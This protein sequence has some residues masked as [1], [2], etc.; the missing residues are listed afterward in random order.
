M[1]P[2]V[3]GV[4]ISFRRHECSSVRLGHGPCLKAEAGTIGWKSDEVVLCFVVLCC[5]CASFVSR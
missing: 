1:I 4:V 3:A 5:G 2:M